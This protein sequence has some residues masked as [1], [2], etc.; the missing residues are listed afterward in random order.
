MAL[1]IVVAELEGLQI[2]ALRAEIPQD[3][4]GIGGV[5][6]IDESD[7]RERVVIPSPAAYPCCGARLMKLGEDVTETLEGRP[8][9][10]EGDQD[11]A[12]SGRGGESVALVNPSARGLMLHSAAAATCDP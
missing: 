8:A 6:K 1:D 3:A 5:Q 4:V 12:R 11:R 7:R 9:A 2:G 10:V